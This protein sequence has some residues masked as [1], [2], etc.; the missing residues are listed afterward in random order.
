MRKLSFFNYKGG[1]GKTCTVV[2]VAHSLAMKG[3]K[4]L[5]LDLD[6]QGSTSHHLGISTKKTIR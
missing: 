5:I 4:I 2:N 6:P 3:Y 1:T